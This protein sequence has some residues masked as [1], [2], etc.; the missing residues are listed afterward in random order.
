MRHREQAAC[1]EDNSKG[2]QYADRAEAIQGFDAFPYKR[3]TTGVMFKQSPPHSSVIIMRLR[4]QV[5]STTPNFS[6]LAWMS[7]HTKVKQA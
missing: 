6:D 5:A 2:H 4:V 1:L 3:D 7:R